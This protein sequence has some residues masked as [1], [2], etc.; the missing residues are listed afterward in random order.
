MLIRIASA[1]VLAVAMAACGSASS[2]IRGGASARPLV[3]ATWVANDGSVLVVNVVLPGPAGAD[4][5]R[6]FAERYRQEHPDA[7]VVVRFFPSTAGPERF[8][9]GYVPTDGGSQPVSASPDD[10]GATYDFPG[11][12]RPRDAGR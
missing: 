2:S 10:P 12:P 11:P 7:R 4:E 8:V 1:V 9:V 3:A 5:L 6:G